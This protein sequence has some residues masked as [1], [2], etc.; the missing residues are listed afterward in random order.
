MSAFLAYSF[1]ICLPEKEE[2]EIDKK[3]IQNRKDFSLAFLRSTRISFSVY[4]IYLFAVSPAYA[5]AYVSDK[6]TRQ[7]NWFK[8]I[9]GIFMATGRFK[10]LL[11]ILGSFLKIP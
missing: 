8:V 10:E 2:I 1:S 5:F 4:C 11:Q 6:G 3:V 7:I 9:F